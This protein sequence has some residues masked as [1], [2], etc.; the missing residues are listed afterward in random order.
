[1]PFAKTNREN[2]LDGIDTRLKTITTANGYRNTVVTVS[3]EIKEWDT[4]GGATA[5]PWLGF[6]PGQETIEHQPF[7]EMRRALPVSV[8][9]H[10]IS[11][12]A[13]DRNEK[14]SDLMRDVKKAM[15]VDPTWTNNAMT[16][17]LQSEQA[18]DGDPD[19]PDSRGAGGSFVQEWQVIYFENVSE[20]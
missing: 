6:M 10:V 16:T 12:S 13:V 17:L 5:K 19:A 8:V 1:M 15:N 9:G 14:L 2:I 18:D 4:S 11:T 7:G 20:E 3:R